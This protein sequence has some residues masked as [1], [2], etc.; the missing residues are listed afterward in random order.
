MKT[1]IKLWDS[2]CLLLETVVDLLVPPVQTPSQ[3]PPTT[4]DLTAEDANEQ[5]AESDAP[6]PAGTNSQ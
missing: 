6:P 5:P 1:K 2:S 4:S 3:A